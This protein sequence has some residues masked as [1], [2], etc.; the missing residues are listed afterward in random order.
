M[1]LVNNA[2]SQGSIS[3]ILPLRPSASAGLYAVNGFNVLEVA[4]DLLIVKVHQ[5]NQLRALCD[6]D[7]GMDLFKFQPL[8]C[9]VI[10][11]VVSLCAMMIT[12]ASLAKSYGQQSS[13][14]HLR[15]LLVMR[16]RRIVRSCALWVAVQLVPETI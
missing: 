4:S 6:E 13:A 5:V 9:R 16:L 8:S 3:G 1:L 10:K 2:C 15:A 7:P 12:R 11:L 14:E